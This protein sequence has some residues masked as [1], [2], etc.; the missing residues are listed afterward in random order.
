MSAYPLL[1]V[2]PDLKDEEL[3]YLQLLHGKKQ[4]EKHWTDWM[5]D[6]SFAE[7]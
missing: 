7:L 1:K 4:R 6:N 2:F 3:E 5:Q